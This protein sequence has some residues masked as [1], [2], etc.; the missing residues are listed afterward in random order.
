MPRPKVK[1]RVQHLADAHGRLLQ[2]QASLKEVDLRTTSGELREQVRDARDQ[3]GAALTAV[4]RAIELDT[5]APPTR[6]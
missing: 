5:P 1:S 4:Q 3:V 2:A 6:K